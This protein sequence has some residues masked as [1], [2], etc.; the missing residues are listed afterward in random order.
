MIGLAGTALA[1]PA[2][3]PFFTEGTDPKPE[4][5]I[6][7]LVDGLSDEFNGDTIDAAKWQTEPYQNGWTWI[8]RPPGLF[9][10]ENVKVAD[11]SMQVEVSV[12]PEPVKKG[13]S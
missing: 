8:G 2:D 4:G 6:W 11:G 1:A 13:R 5:K 3:G 9:K 12:L 7:S 10:A